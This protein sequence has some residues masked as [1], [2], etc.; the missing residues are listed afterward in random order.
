[1]GGVIKEREVAFRGEKREARGAIWGKKGKKKRKKVR[2]M[3]QEKREGGTINL[4]VKSG[5]QRRV[6]RKEL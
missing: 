5:Y 2:E 3:V 4:G 1:M 6:G